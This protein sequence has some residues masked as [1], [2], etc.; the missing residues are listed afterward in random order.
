MLLTQLALGQ[1]C[2]PLPPTTRDALILTQRGGHWGGPG[3]T[4]LQADL[5][6]AVTQETAASL[7]GGTHR[8]P[9]PAS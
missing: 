6:A 3:A 4:L 9:S 2:T 5:S 7:E 1:E 8:L